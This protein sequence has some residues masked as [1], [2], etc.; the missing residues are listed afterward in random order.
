MQLVA[1]IA[2][3]LSARAGTADSRRRTVVALDA[4]ALRH[5]SGGSPR[6]TWLSSDIGGQGASPRGTWL[7]TEGGGQASSPRGTW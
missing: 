4:S 1:L 7:G 6:G 5:V 3:R 2:R